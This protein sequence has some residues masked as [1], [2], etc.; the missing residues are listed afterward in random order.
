VD[1]HGDGMIGGARRAC[2]GAWWRAALAI[3]RQVARSSD[4][5]ETAHY[6]TICINNIV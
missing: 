1:L 5:T 2:N 4:A 3:A 6:P